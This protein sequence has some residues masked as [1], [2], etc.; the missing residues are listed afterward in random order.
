VAGG[1]EL[2]SLPPARDEAPAKANDAKTSR[3]DKGC[4]LQKPNLKLSW[5]TRGSRL[6]DAQVSRNSGLG[7]SD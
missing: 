5:S 2:R 4:M 7:L 6:R 1:S 3:R